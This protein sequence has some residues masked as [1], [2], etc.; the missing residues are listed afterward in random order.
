M[1][2]LQDY[3]TAK[4][5]KQVEVAKALKVGQSTVATWEAGLTYPRAGHML[6]LAKLLGID[7][8]DVIKS[9]TRSREVREQR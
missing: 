6:K 8:A 3:R 9:I 1:R 7:V 4:N 2:T 5:L